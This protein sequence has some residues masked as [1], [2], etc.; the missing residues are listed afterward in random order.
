MFQS[1]RAL[2]DA[3]YNLRRSFLADNSVFQSSRA[4]ADARY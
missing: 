3:R 4:L 2:A 1:S